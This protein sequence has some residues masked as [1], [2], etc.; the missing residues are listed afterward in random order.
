M[1]SCF[2]TSYVWL[3]NSNFCAGPVSKKFKYIILLVTLH[4]HKAW[5]FT[6]LTNV[7]LTKSTRRICFFFFFSQKVFKLVL[8]GW[9]LVHGDCC[10]LWYCS[11]CNDIKASWSMQL[12]NCGGHCSLQCHRMKYDSIYIIWKPC[13]NFQIRSATSIFFFS[14]STWFKSSS[15]YYKL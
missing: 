7:C 10:N 14:M 1:V 11:S 9:Q 2:S 4:H 5:A 6:V 12:G 3:Y 13:S 8:V 15:Y